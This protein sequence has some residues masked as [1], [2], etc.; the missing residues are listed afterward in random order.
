VG[1]GTGAAALGAGA[2]L[3]TGAAETVGLVSSGGGAGLLQAVN[4]EAS[5]AK[6]AGILWEIIIEDLV[7]EG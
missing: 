3:A 2:A 5:K 4:V 7:C 1:V 6:Y